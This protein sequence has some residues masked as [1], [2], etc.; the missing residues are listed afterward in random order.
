MLAFVCACFIEYSG[1]SPV[2]FI[3]VNLARIPLALEYSGDSPVAFI[4]VNLARIPLVLEYSGDSPVAFIGVNLARIPLA[5]EYSGDSPVAFIG[6]VNL[7]RR[8]LDKGQN[9]ALALEI[10]PHIMEFT[11]LDSPSFHA[12][13]RRIIP[14]KSRLLHRRG[15]RLERDC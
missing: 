3:G 2:A 15:Q 10:E 8:H 1:D 7:A 12:N 6:G 11:F 4:G 9:I 5:L 13:W 14:L